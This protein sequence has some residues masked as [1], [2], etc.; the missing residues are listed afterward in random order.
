MFNKKD[1]NQRPI[2][3]LVMIFCGLSIGWLT[4]SFNEWLVPI[5]N[6]YF[7]LVKLFVFPLVLLSIIFGLSQFS[8][9][10]QSP[11]RFLSALILSVVGL[12]V[13]GLLT[14]LICEIFTPGL[15]MPNEFQKII[16]ELSLEKNQVISIEWKNSFTEI[17]INEFAS[18]IPSNL[19]NAFAY[20]S[21]AP[22]M[23]GSLIFALGFSL[24]PVSK[25]KYLFE[26]LEVLYIALENLIIIVN[27]ITPFIALI[28]ASNLIASAQFK[29]FDLSVSFLTPF[30][31][32]IALIGFLCSYIISWFAEIKFSLILKSL[33]NAM[34]VSFLARMPAAGVPEVIQCLCD[35]FGFKRSI[36][37][38][39]SPLLPIF[40]NA[41]E[42]VFYVLITIYISNIYGRPLGESDLIWI[43]MCS[44]LCSLVSSFSVTAG[45]T[46]M[47][48]LIVKELNIPFDAFFPIFFIFDFFI[49]GAKSSLAILFSSCV[50]AVIS[51]GLE[52]DPVSKEWNN[53]NNFE[54]FY[55]SFQF[56]KKIVLIILILFLI[57]LITVFLLGLGEGLTVNN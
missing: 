7:S 53:D 9:L 34:M 13:C 37:R 49:S 33:T 24:L 39:L 30:I 31:I 12:M 2:F 5:L 4:P 57:F 38:F 17:K 52:R 29:F 26:R 35:Q 14:I 6:A 54:Q 3:F 41:G 50:V 55:F 32:T 56:N 43:V 44:I 8:T 48:A 42:V 23:I 27:K 28:F 25:N 20:Q 11:Q 22:A 15:K 18:L 46:L 16:G 10:P 47:S 21:L 51:K 40:F 36:V 19:L 1:W 45:P